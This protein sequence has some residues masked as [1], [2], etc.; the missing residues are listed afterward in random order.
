MR[1]SF[2]VGLSGGEAVSAAVDK[3]FRKFILRPV[4]EIGR[5]SDMML[6]TESR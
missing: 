4:P 6:V 3:G 2:N 5:E 1:R